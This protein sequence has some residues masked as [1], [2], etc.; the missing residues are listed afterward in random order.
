MSALAAQVE[1]SEAASV[2]HVDV[3]L[4]LAEAANGP[5]EA[6]PGGLVQSCVT[7]QLV[8]VVQTGSLLHQNLHHGQVTSSGR[9]LQ[10]RVTCL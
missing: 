3:G 10:C 8:L 1:G 7:V 6:L 2:L 5:T 9:P 4:R